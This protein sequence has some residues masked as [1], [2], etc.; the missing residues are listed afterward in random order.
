MDS[1]INGHP[2]CRDSI[3]M[4]GVI[5]CTNYPVINGH[6][7][8]WTGILLLFL[9]LN[10]RTVLYLFYFVD[11]T[12]LQTLSNVFANAHTPAAACPRNNYASRL[13]ASLEKWKRGLIHTIIKMAAAGRCRILMLDD[14]VDV[15]K[16]I[17][18]GEYCRSV[19]AA[20]T[21]GKSQISRIR[22][23]RAAILKEWESGAR[24]DLKYVKRR[25]GTY[26]ELNTLVRERF[27]KA[28]SICSGL[29]HI[30][31]VLIFN[32]L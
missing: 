24:Y 32:T 8:T 20:V 15:L 6:L 14:R 18:N 21:C 5:F 2:L 25:K 16:R 13:C 23:D 11:H 29:L 17:D 19:T 27:N 28:R 26:E 3:T 12:G 7:L 1:V 4:Y 30:Y 9:P 22:S 31:C 10:Q